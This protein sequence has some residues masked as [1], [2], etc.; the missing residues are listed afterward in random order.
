[1]YEMIQFKN[2]YKKVFEYQDS[3][4]YWAISIFHGL[5]IRLLKLHSGKKESLIKQ[6]PLLIKSRDLDISS[7]LFSAR[8]LPIPFI[9]HPP[10][11][12]STQ[13]L[14]P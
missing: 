10:P 11:P 1:M 3:K 14:W 6:S 12:Y 13:S 7:F 8:I 9:N 4:W 2:I 5:R